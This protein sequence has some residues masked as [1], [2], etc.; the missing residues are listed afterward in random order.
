MFKNS[1]ISIKYIKKVSKIWQNDIF[2]VQYIC[3]FNLLHLI[4]MEKVQPLLKIEEQLLKFMAIEVNLLRVAIPILVAVLALQIYALIQ[5]VI[6][7]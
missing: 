5:G 6:L 1:L 2:C 4:F 3:T 7:L